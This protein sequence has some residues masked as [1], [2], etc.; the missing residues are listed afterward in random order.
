ML[1]TWWGADKTCGRVSCVTRLLGRVLPSISI[2]SICLADIYSVVCMVAV[3]LL[4]WRILPIPVLYQTLNRV[5]LQHFLLSRTVSLSFT[6]CVTSTSLTTFKTRGRYLGRFH[7]I[8]Q[9]CSNRPSNSTPLIKQNSN[10][11]PGIPLRRRQTHE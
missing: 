3:L 9:F 7:I 2:S 6:D 5:S 4:V 11:G 10:T 1:L 8:S